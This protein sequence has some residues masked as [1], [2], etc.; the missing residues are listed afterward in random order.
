M[1]RVE[2]GLSEAEKLD[3]MVTGRFFAY[4]SL[5]NRRQ[6]VEGGRLQGVGAFLRQEHA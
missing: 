5:R 4:L 3:A 2:G 1:D 6:G